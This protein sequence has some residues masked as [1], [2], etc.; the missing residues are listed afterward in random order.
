MMPHPCYLGS[1]KGGWMSKALIYILDDIG[2]VRKLLAKQLSGVHGVDIEEGTRREIVELL[3]K[4]QALS[5]PR[6]IITDIYSDSDALPL[7]Y[8]G[9]SPVV[10]DDAQDQAVKAELDLV[11][12]I[13][14]T[15]PDT[16]IIVFSNFQES[17]HFTDEQKRFVSEFL[18]SLGIVEKQ[19]IAKQPLDTGIRTVVSLIESDLSFPSTERP[20][21]AVVLVVEDMEEDRKEITSRLELEGIKVVAA[22]SRKEAL[23]KLRYCIAEHGRV[24]D[25]IITDLYMPPEY[26]TAGTRMVKEIKEGRGVFDSIID[27]IKNDLQPLRESLAEVPIIVFSLYAVSDKLDGPQVKAIE[28]KLDNLGI[29]PENRIAKTGRFRER[30]DKVVKRLL[31]I[32]RSNQESK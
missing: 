29:K 17:L 30:I 7:L 3:K 11:K 21:D 4:G 1:I 26:E 18:T 28:Q 31:E 20:S 12:T 25:C 6:I 10:T 13:V 2:K 27:G 16:R 24:P 19:I 23:Q 32:L 14:E 5:E 9:I 22:S 8:E 15:W